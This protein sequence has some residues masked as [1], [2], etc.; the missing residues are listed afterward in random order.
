MDRNRVTRASTIAISLMA[1]C[2]FAKAAEKEKTS[3][4]NAALEPMQGQVVYYRSQVYND[5]Q[6]FAIC[7]TNLSDKPKPLI[8]DLVPGTYSRVERAAKDC[9][10][11]CQ[12]AAENDLACVAIRPSGRGNGS[13]YQGYGEVDVYEAINAVVQRLA[14]DPDRISV[15][16]VSMGGAATWYHVSHKPDFWA[17]AAPFCGYC[18]YKLW[19][20]PGGTTFHRQVWEEPSWIAR[21]A[22]YRTPNLRNVALR[23]VHG[24]WD[25]A[26]GGGV[27]VEHSRRMS[28][29]LTALNIA[30]EYIEIPRSPHGRDAE[31]WRKTIPWLLRQ[32][33]DPEPRRV[34]LVVH[35]L[36]HARAYWVQT[37][38]QERYGNAST[39][40]ARFEEKVVIVETQ[41]VQRIEIGPIPHA[42][43][44]TVTVK[45]DGTTFE[46][47]GIGNAHEFVRASDGQWSQ[48][49]QP[50]PDGR[51][52][53]RLSGPFSD[54]FYQPTVI[55]H[56]TCGSAE[57]TRF[58]EMMAHNIPRTFRRYNGGVHRGGIMGENSV[59]LPVLTD[60]HYL[61]ITSTDAK[62]I[63]SDGI[64]LDKTLL[65][66]S[67][68]WCIGDFSSNAVL[69]K[70]AADLPIRY[71]QGEIEL[72]GKTY[73]GRHLAFFAI[74]PHPDNQRYV[75]LLSG[76]EP[77]A[78]TWGSHV[79]HQLLPDYLIFDHD[80]VVEW[81]FWNNHWRHS[82]R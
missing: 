25:R 36:R 29:K 23:I 40:E 26:V 37:L 47:I 50:I 78:I 53:P 15:T 21:G 71:G 30:H 41:N 6:P 68:L 34:S 74:L 9:E 38:Q 17:A 49:H 67:N 58:N 2:G 75:A 1:A 66:R 59:P 5:L 19:D 8:V 18:D 20:K 28:R 35:T 10:Y 76:I 62:P 3:I 52:R 14:I 13:V 11:I 27:P 65:Q 22:A 69:A 31:Q 7:A 63:E 43:V 51:K 79:G 70:L 46:K 12:V 56:G 72:G 82:Q 60:E 32:K 54:L 48:T 81:G 39:V 77:D 24:E 80:R 55:V 73:R 64:T 16:G 57:Q 4:E 45:L 42:D 33:R 61:N 44:D